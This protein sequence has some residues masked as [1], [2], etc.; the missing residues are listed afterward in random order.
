VND[1]LRPVNTDV[2]TIRRALVD[3]GLMTRASGV[4]R[5]VKVSR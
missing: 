1:L 4:Y 5:R 2:A 3:H